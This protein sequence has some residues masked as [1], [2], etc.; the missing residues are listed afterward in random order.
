MPLAGFR[1]VLPPLRERTEDI[2]GL[3]LA[4]LAESGSEKGR[5]L[6]GFSESAERSLLS[7][8]W[9]GNIRELRDVVERAAILTQGQ[10]IGA[11]HLG[12]PFPA[13]EENF[14]LGDPVSLD[15]VEEAHIRKVLSVAKSLEE[16]ARI[17]GIDAATLWRRR[18]RYGL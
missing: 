14:A 18:K 11:A 3:A 16:A 7:H 6:V 12:L 13:P 4:F 10:Q 5:K 1:L 15:R 17:L 2:P 8:A 9:P